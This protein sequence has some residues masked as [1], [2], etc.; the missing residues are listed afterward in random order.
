MLLRESHALPRDAG[1]WLPIVYLTLVGS[2]LAFVA[3][4]WLVQRWSVVRISFIAVITPVFATALG[5]LVRHER[6]G[7]GALLGALI[8]LAGVSLAVTSDARDRAARVLR[9]IP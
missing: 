2:V 1:A 6:L 4:A 5:S 8:V 7:A 3:F 9:P